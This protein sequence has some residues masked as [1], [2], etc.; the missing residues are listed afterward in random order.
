M[1]IRKIHLKNYKVFDDI[2]LDFTD[3]N[4]KT[5]DT[6][7]LAG[8]NGCGKTTLLEFIASLFDNTYPYLNGSKPYN[9]EA[10]E[11]LGPNSILKSPEFEVE[12]EMNKEEERYINFHNNN[13]ERKQWAN[14]FTYNSNHTHFAYAL[15]NVYSGMDIQVVYRLTNTKTI[16]E[17][18][19]PKEDNKLKIVSIGEVEN[20]I[21]TFLQIVTDKALANVDVAPSKTYEEI[22]NAVNNAFNDIDIRTKLTSLDAKHIQFTNENGV[23]LDFDD[24]SAGEKSLYFMSFV[25][26]QFDL[27]NGILMIDEPEDA[28][29]PTWQQQLVRFY[30]NIGTNNQV[31]LATHS[32][33]IIGAVP[34]ENLFLLK[35]ENGKITVSQPKY[36]EGHS[37]AYVL[38]EIMETDYRNTYTN[39][40]VDAYLALIGKGEQESAKGQELWNEIQHL[41]PNSEERMQ[42]DFALRRFQVL[43]K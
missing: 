9:K 39:R 28:L 30:Q 41:D 23:K 20:T 25:L 34:A 19:K 13:I 24:L 12:F 6:I 15:F 17:A 18:T 26:N 10:Y 14:T 27:A 43:K 40:L 8:V 5:L 16:N 38:S 33:H 42:I 7:V 29:H 31:F 11:I 21:K 1:K 32:P 35:P 22:K 2:L 4:G 3:K 37:V 36:S